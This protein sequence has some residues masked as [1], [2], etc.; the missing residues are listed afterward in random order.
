MPNRIC[1]FGLISFYATSLAVP[2]MGTCPPG[3]G[4][5]ILVSLTYTQWCG[6]MNIATQPFHG[7]ISK[8]GFEG[9]M[10]SRPCTII[11]GGTYDN[12]QDITTS[13]VFSNHGAYPGDTITFS[14][15]STNTCSDAE[16][17]SVQ[18]GRPP[19]TSTTGV[20]IFLRIVFSGKN[21]AQNMRFFEITWS[22]F[23]GIK[24]R[25]CMSM[26][27][28][29]VTGPENCAPCG[30][31]LS[32]NEDRTECQEPKCPPGSTGLISEGCVMCVAGKYKNS[33]GSAECTNC[34][35]GKYSNV[36]GR[37]VCT[38]C[39]KGKYSPGD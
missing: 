4:T 17:I 33:S 34:E 7:K 38:D 5:N 26:T 31:G 6:Q 1:F 21:V 15:C 12:D 36:A 19:P 11:L 3:S 16:V 22:V 2:V 18:T 37:A 28:K 13:A 39:V 29:A 32:S 23:R 27:F 14:K 10:F 8:L 35:P 9:D 24:C 20:K 30:T 25:E